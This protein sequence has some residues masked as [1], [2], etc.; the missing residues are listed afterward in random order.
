GATALLRDDIGR[1]AVGAKADL[2]L[3][4]LS[5]RWMQPVRDPLRCLLFHA[6]DRA[7][8]HVF[9]DG[10]QVVRDGEVV[11]LDHRG[12]LA[13]LVKDQRRMEEMVPGL[14]PRGR[15]SLDI[16]PLSLPWAAGP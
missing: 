7:V 8:R 12:A 16:A 15:A 14:D 4:D 11:T 1:L 10:R 3:V 13:T 6:A 2:V 9:V 5:E